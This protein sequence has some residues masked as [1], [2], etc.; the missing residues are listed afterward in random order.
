MSVIERFLNY[1]KF[2]TQSKVD[3]EDY[4]STSKQLVLLNHLVKEL[5]TL[6]I[7]T[8]ID[9]YG[10]VIGKIASNVKESTKTIALIAHVDTSPDASGKDVL[11]RIV[12]NYD[13]NTIVLNREN[14]VLLDPKIFPNLKDKIG[15]DLIVTDGNTLL[16]ADDK[17]GVAEIM[18]FAEFVMKNPSYLHGEIVIV[19][20]PDE[21]VGNGTKFFDT[22]KVGADFGYTMDGSKVG[23]IAYENFN[24]AT[25]K[26]HINGKSVHPGSAK[27]K[28]LN[29][30]DVAYEF[31]NLLPKFMRAEITENYEGFNHLLNIN[32]AVEKTEMTYIIRNHDKEIFEKQKQDFYTNQ[33]FLN[34]K[35]GSNTINVKITDSYYNMREILDNNQDIVNIAIKAIKD[36][37]LN[38]IIE[39]IRGGT[40]GAR[41]A[42][43]GLPCPNLG[44]GGYNFH[45]PF[46]YASVKEMNLAVEIIKT[47]VSE[48]V[49]I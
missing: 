27:N 30:I 38:P 25:A 45:G 41:L 14:N 49:N 11:A 8:T 48:V 32:G 39:P 21:E 10:Y 24:A 44:T 36:N 12:K 28:M 31:N 17:L 46:E 22:K 3:V 26:I 20:T 29:A 1:V 40:D 18:D 47:I 5:K 16:G 33:E 19:F 42:F 35:Y 37:G 2:D 13:G 9:E 43:M 7:Q 23:E 34:K 4:P 6:N 15:D